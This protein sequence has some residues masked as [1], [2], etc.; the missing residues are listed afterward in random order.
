MEHKTEAG[1]LTEEEKAILDEQIEQ[2]ES[3]IVSLQKEKDN[4][5]DQLS[6]LLDKRHPEKK[7][8]YIKNI[9]F[10]T[11]LKST[12]SLEEI[13]GY[14]LADETEDEDNFFDNWHLV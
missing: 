3:K 4:L 5:C 10:Q 14:M 8:D 13:L 1:Q 7:D 11:Y 6:I 9:L 2:L 12:K